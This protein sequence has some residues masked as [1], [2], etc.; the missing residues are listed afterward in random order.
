MAWIEG[1]GFAP[2]V[3]PIAGDDGEGLTWFP[4]PVERVLIAAVAI[5][6][7]HHQILTMHAAA[8]AVDI[9][10]NMTSAIHI[11]IH[12]HAVKIIHMNA[13][14][15]QDLPQFC[16]I[17]RN[18]LIGERIGFGNNGNN[19]HLFLNLFHKMAINFQKPSRAQKVQT[20]VDQFILGRI[21]VILQSISIIVIVIAGGHFPL[22]LALPTGGNVVGYGLD[23][24]AMIDLI[25]EAR[26]V[27][28]ADAEYCVC[29]RVESL[30]ETGCID[31]LRGRTLGAMASAVRLG[32]RVEP[33][34]EEGRAGCGLA[35]AREACH[36]DVKGDDAGS[37]L[38]GFRFRG[39][40]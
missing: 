3:I 24:I 30:E 17:Y 25:T 10:M 27:D 28:D 8:A 1:T 2:G 12:I 5:S 9:I 15:F 11:H 19:R 23:G 29:V 39:W 6:I 37:E 31:D 40:Q 36:H 14:P 21:D 35:E 7:G 32:S 26:G 34:I 20:H 18:F 38:E 4:S 16:P 33:R 13:L 22:V